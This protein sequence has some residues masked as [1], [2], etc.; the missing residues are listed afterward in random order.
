MF[1]YTYHI[2]VEEAIKSLDLEGYNLGSLRFISERKSAK[3][4]GFCNRA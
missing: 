3:I 2:G 1:L 4:K